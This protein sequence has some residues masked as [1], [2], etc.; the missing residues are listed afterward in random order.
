MRGVSYNVIPLLVCKFVWKGNKGYVVGLGRKFVVYA[1]FESQRKEPHNYARVADECKLFQTPTVVPVSIVW[2]GIPVDHR[3]YSVRLLQATN[4]CVA[5]GCPTGNFLKRY[6]KKYTRSIR[7][8]VD[9]WTG[10]H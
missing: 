9:L 10:K 8:V 6:W 2:D 1:D 7:N 3:F 4:A 5:Y